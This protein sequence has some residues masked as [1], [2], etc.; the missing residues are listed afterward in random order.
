MPSRTS[1]LTRVALAAAVALSGAVATTALATATATVAQAAS[2]VDGSITRSEVLARADYWYQKRANIPYDQGGSYQDSSGRSYRTDCS[3]YVSM[4]WHTGTSYSTRTLPGVAT[5]IPRS[6]LK[7]GDILN[8][9]EDH[10]ILFE[11]WDDTAKT[12]FSYYSF[13]STPVKH[14]TSISINAAKFDDHPNGDYKAYRYNKIVDDPAV[15]SVYS[16]DVPVSGRWGVGSA[17]TVGVFRNGTWALRG[18]NGA[19]TA[20]GFGQAGDLPM[21]GDFDGVGHDQLGVFRP[22]IG[23]FV[24]RHD[25]GS[26]TSLAF[27]QAGDIPVPGMWDHNGHAQ[28]ALYRPSTGTFVVRHDDG[29]VSTAALGQAGDTPIVGDWD[30]VGHTQ[31]GVFRPGTNAGS[32]NTFILRHDDGSVTTAAYGVKGDLPVV[33]DWSSK[34]RTTYGVYRPGTATFAL[35]NA[36]AGTADSVFTYGNGGTWS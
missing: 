12:T 11:K 19:T 34:G 5:E 18:A 3:G 29:S 30:G 32:Q 10:V 9:F 33:G 21:T 27:G 6:Q 2:S 7:P 31:M 15:P 25:D 20:V 4:A 22:S 35:S 28:M 23:T 17:T 14:Y 26:A 8:S 16:G 24:V 36:Y 13:G 1:K